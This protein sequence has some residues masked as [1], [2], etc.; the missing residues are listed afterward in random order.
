MTPETLVIFRFVF[1]QALEKQTA[2]LRK[3]TTELSLID[4]ILTMSAKL[5]VRRDAVNM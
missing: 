1:Q 3:I 4:Q 2:I 5:R